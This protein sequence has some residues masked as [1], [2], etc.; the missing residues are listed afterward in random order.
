MGRFNFFEKKGVRQTIT[1]EEKP[2]KTTTPGQETAG[3]SGS[4][5]GGAR[6]D[7]SGTNAAVS[8]QQK[9][10]AVKEKSFPSFDDFPRYF[11]EIFRKSFQL[12]GVFYGKK[13]EYS[14][15]LGE[16]LLEKITAQNISLDKKRE[17]RNWPE[18]SKKAYKE[19]LIKE[20]DNIDFEIAKI[21]N[22]KTS[23]EEKNQEI[24]QLYESRIHKPI[25]DRMIMEVLESIPEEDRMT[26]AEVEEKIKNLT[27]EAAPFKGPMKEGTFD[28]ALRLYDKIERYRELYPQHAESLKKINEG[29]EKYLG[30]YIKIRTEMDTTNDVEVF[31]SIVKRVNEIFKKIG[32]IKRGEGD[33]R[34]EILDRLDEKK[35]TDL[36][37]SKKLT[38]EQKESI[39]S[40]LERIREIKK[41]AFPE[42]AAKQSSSKKMG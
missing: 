34:L 24:H 36:E 38:N 3:L 35:L 13:Y 41:L 15:K 19:I 4:R 16:I 30:G 10:N 31:E 39:K 42:Q 11:E 23:D 40:V 5:A 6:N 28:S 33:T 12:G 22:K 1:E 2:V 18:E 29:L 26:T 25:F 9:D 21:R 37:K 27:S 32:P 8:S 14:N 20:G 17:H 7:A